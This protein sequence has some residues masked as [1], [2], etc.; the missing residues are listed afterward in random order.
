MSILNINCQSSVSFPV[1]CLR[2]QPSRKLLY[3]GN[4]C[5]E[6][7]TTCLYFELP[8]YSMLKKLRTA[9]LLLFKVCGRYERFCGNHTQNQYYVSPLLD[10]FSPYSYLYPIPQQDPLQRVIYLDDPDSCCTE[11][12]IT[13]IVTSWISQTIENK[14]LILFGC[15]DSPRITYASE[16]FDVCATQ[17]ILRLIYDENKFCDLKCVSCNVNVND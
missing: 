3:I 4:Y 16:S 12:D 15:F 10:Y 17:P 14:G 11:I 8:P 13:T 9:K 7:Y 5:G 1:G 6:D 2:A